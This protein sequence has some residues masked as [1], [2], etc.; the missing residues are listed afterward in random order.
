MDEIDKVMADINECNRRTRL[1]KEDIEYLRECSWIRRMVGLPDVFF[2][3]W[4]NQRRIN[5][6]KK[7]LIEIGNHL[8]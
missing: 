1:I 4:M 2:A 8:Q 5:R 6:A 3:I 7:A